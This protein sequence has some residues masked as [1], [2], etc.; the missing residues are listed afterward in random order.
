MPP[1]LDEGGWIVTAIE[2]TMIGA[3]LGFI[4]LAMFGASGPI[5]K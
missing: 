3:A 4:L 1:E 2:L 5:F